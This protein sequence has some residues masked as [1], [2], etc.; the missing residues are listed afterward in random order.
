MAKKKSRRHLDDTAQQQQQEGNS[1][2]DNFEA[3]APWPWGQHDEGQEK[4]QQM[5]VDDADNWGAFGKVNNDGLLDSAPYNDKLLDWAA[6]AETFAAANLVDKLD[7]GLSIN[8]EKESRTGTEYR[9]SDP[10]DIPKKKP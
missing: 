8:N 5:V 10:W 4:A 3:Q 9:E 6:P 7:D 2:N 1:N